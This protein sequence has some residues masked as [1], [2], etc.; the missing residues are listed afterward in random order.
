M[1]RWIR[2]PWRW[3]G[4]GALVACGSS[5]ESGAPSEPEPGAPDAAVDAGAET[6]IDAAGGE[7]PGAP[8]NV[9]AEAVAVASTVTTL[10]GS[11]TA[12]FADGTGSAASFTHPSGIAVD[13]AGN[14]YVADKYNHRIR[15]VTSAGVVTTLA[16]SG[17]GTFADGTG[18]AA[19]F[20]FPADVAVDGAG[21]VW[22]ADKHGHRVRKV[23][24]EGV[25]TTLAGSGTA[26]VADGTGTAASF[27]SPVGIALDAAANL[28]VADVGVDVVPNNRIRKVTPAGVVTTLA[29]S[30][31]AAFADGTGA[32]ASF[33]YPVGVAVDGAGN[34]YVADSNNH[35]I[36]K[37]TPAGVVT[38]LAGSGKGGFADGTGGAAGFNFPMGVAVDAAG[39]VFVADYGSNRI[40]RVTAAG[41][42]TTLAGSDASGS[43][44]G[45]GSAA[46]FDYPFGVAVDAAGNVF[47]SDYES[48][49][50]RKLAVVGVGQLAVRW[51]PPSA[52]GASAVT[53][54]VASAFAE[55]HATQ[56][57]TTT[58]ATSCTIGG[59]TSGVAYRVSVT[60][61]DA[62]GTSAP[63]TSTTA[64]PN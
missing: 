36:R 4:A 31:A 17:E 26:A 43:A 20:T 16:G 29:G 5:G 35:R 7:A 42:V 14:V 33:D 60:A 9:V 10:A 61:T 12:A 8:S 40:R 19:S 41:V 34:V 22:V 18:A 47:V 55:G 39:N 46:T 49:L 50:I 6:P 45:E 54:Y 32:A 27:T 59:L 25:V 11:G 1:A 63:S 48:H 51:S 37:V 28:Y 15:K 13:A 30:D 64:T 44:D 24:A 62:T 23:T 21:N 58:G 52:P 57:C 2:H 38:T 3:L 56:T 53:R